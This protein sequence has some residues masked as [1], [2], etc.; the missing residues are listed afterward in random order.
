M[1]DMSSSL[2]L[3][4]L[5]VWLV[6]PLVPSEQGNGTFNATAAT[7]K[8]RRTQSINSHNQH[9]SKCLRNP[10]IESGI[11]TDEMWKNFDL[12]AADFHWDSPGLLMRLL[13]QA[14][15]RARPAQLY[16]AGNFDLV[17]GAASDRSKLISTRTKKYVVNGDGNQVTVG[18]LSVE[19][20]QPVLKDR[21]A[22]LG[23]IGGCPVKKYWDG[24]HND[25]MKWLCGVEDTLQHDNCIIYSVGSNNEYEF[26]VEMVKSTKCKI[27]IFDCTIKPHVPAN[28]ADR[29]DFKQ[30]CLGPSDTLANGRIFKTL[31]TIQAELEHEQIDLLKMDIEGFE[32]DVIGGFKKHDNLPFQMAI[33]LHMTAFWNSASLS[34]AGRRMTIGE[35]AMWGGRMYDLGY[36]PVASY[37]NTRWPQCRELTWVRYRCRHESHH[38]SFDQND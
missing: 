30:W 6:I 28:I 10:L 1:I 36:V 20:F 34:W 21:F 13:T 3:S 26:E 23:P 9:I 7:M 24:K 33:E 4:L 5:T 11:I 37:G 16:P 31:P 27:F 2:L 29:V 38:K 32:W 17:P 8:W 18:N 22:M 25:G 15:K 12:L 19:S 14:T 35:M